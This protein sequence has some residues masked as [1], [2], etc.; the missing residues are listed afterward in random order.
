MPKQFEL[1]V[2]SNTHWDREWLYSFQETRLF[3]VQF[4]DTLLEIL[5]SR[6]DYHS[7]LLDSQ[8]VP[9][10]DYLE[11]HPER[12]Q[13][14]E[15]YVRSK[16]L[17]VG[18]WYTL[19][20]EFLVSAE[21]LVR[22]LV[23]GHRVAGK[24]GHVMKIGYSPFS[25]GQI[26]QMPQVYNGFGIDT[27]LFYHG[28]S[29]DES[30]A[31][32]I[33]EGPDGSRLFASRMGSFARYNF[34]YH[35]FRPLVYNKAIHERQFD[36][37]EGGLPFHFCS[38]DAFHEHFFLVDPVKYFDKTKIQELVKKFIE[39][40]E[41]HCSTTYL[42]CMQG[43][44]STL[45]DARELDIIGEASKLMKNDRILHSSLPEWMEKAKAAAKNLVV[46][47]GERRT[48]RFIGLR[49]HLYGDVTS[50]RTRM[51]HQNTL[52]EVLLQ[53]L[54]EPFAAAAWL[55]GTPYPKGALTLAWKT[56]LK[57]HPHDSIAG[58]GIDQIER[59]VLNRLEQVQGIS[60]GV[61]RNQLQ[62]I[63]SQIDNS[64]YAPETVL[65]TVFNPLPV[66]RSETLKAVID[67]PQTCDFTHFKL[68]EAASGKEVDYWEVSRNEASPVVRHFGDATMMMDSLR[69][70]IQFFA[71]NLPGMGYRTYYLQPQEKTI[72][73][74]GNL[75]T[76]RNTMENEYLKVIFRDDGTLDLLDKSSGRQFDGLHYFEDCGEAG[77]AWRHVF[78]ANDRLITSHNAQTE[79]SQVYSTPLMAQ[80][81]V[82]TKLAIPAH[83]VEGPGSDIRRLDADG[84]N[85]S[86]SENLRELSL[87]SWFTLRKENRMLEVR[88]SFNNTCADH[89]LRVM[90]PT[91]LMAKHSSADTAFDVIER[92]IDR[93]SDSH[94]AGT[95]NPTHPMSRFID[96]S[97][98]KAGLAIITDGL[99]EFEVTDT[100]ERTIGITL[101][102]AF[103]VALTTVSWRWER[104]PQMTLSQGYGQHEF[105]YAIYPHQG[106]WD[107]GLV[108]KQAE[109]FTVPVQI[110][111]VG[112]HKGHLPKEMS[113]FELDSQEIA[114][115]AVK[116]AED[117]ESLILRLYNP[118]SANK[119]VRIRFFRNIQNCWQ[120]NLNEERQQSQPFKGNQAEIN[121]D[122]KKIVTLEVEL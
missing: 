32:F 59:D 8:V 45:P 49:K 122:S 54:A 95:W 22:N 38:E 41:T 5:K 80:F 70:K 94:W 82:D 121:L 99:K 73:L 24:Y 88:T 13:E 116:Q 35:V 83:L 12:Q 106:N 26:S 103:E 115:S 75:V 53:R 74:E 43:M 87:T 11:I 102:R 64:E 89:R 31:E 111:Q 110:A 16:R 65:F 112:P 100:A 44:D 23:I 118:A 52:T 66:A 48:P 30:D 92:P 113:F 58:T 117:R 50:T 20:E 61:L 85:A 109:H 7:Y 47:K 63:Q 81:R 114:V 90:F 107:S 62:E 42:A 69:V 119:K 4:M 33:F 3:L 46:L 56:L 25:Y 91:N 67:I 34:F 15:S 68:I 77:H 29:P 6:P 104:H 57:C 1:H 86:R 9:I 76:A 79:V 93:G 19:P 98:G 71:E 40:E 28:I 36:W 21:S 84:D 72:R 18:P 101:L 97:D 39:I 120:T 27:I 10:E 37:K 17:M 51:K 105:R 96:V 108:L 2:I 14:I 55:L 78:P 60:R